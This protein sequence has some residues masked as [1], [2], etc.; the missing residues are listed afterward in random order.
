VQGGCSVAVVC[1]SHVPCEGSGCDA[2]TVA[3][4]PEASSGDPASARGPKEVEKRFDF[5]LGVAMG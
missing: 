1:L 5:W 3:T 4:L 2:L